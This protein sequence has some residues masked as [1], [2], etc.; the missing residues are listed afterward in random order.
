MLHIKL[1]SYL[2]YNLGSRSNVQHIVVFL[3][4]KINLVSLYDQKEGEQSKAGVQQGLFSLSFRKRPEWTLAIDEHGNGID[5]VYFSKPKAEQLWS[6]SGPGFALLFTSAIVVAG[7]VYLDSDRQRV[8]RC[9][10]EGVFPPKVFRGIIC[11]YSGAGKQW[12]K[13]TSAEGAVVKI[14]FKGTFGFLYIM[15]RTIL[16][17]FIALMCSKSMYLRN[18]NRTCYILKFSYF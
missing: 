14:V 13:V 6:L 2:E 10:E 11:S 15:G 5:C 1:N 16:I 18:C 17:M 7:L 9:L 3:L 12:M 8:V 4:F